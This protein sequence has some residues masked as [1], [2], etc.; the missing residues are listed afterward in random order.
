MPLVNSNFH[1]GHKL[2]LLPSTQN[3]A[4]QPS[5]DKE[6]VTEE[7]LGNGELARPPPG[8]LQSSDEGMTGF[9]EKNTTITLAIQPS[10]GRPADLCQSVSLC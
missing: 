7:L 1:S 8:L 3:P 10:S 5:D 4:I 9:T 6:E 2:G